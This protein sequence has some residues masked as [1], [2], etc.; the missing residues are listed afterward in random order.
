MYKLGST[1][2]LADT[3]S[4]AYLTEADDTN[5]M[6]DDHDIMLV[7]PLTPSKLTELQEV[8][9][10]DKYAAT[11]VLHHEWMANLHKSSPSR[12]QKVLQLPR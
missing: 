9:A 5:I 11:D 7:T 8:T 6:A 10:K 2:H 4:C 12:T 3:L 1:L